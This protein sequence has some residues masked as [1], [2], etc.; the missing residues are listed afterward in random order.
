V[1]LERGAYAADA[2]PGMLDGPLEGSLY[3]LIRARYDQMP[4]RAVERLEPG[5]A[6]PHEAEVLEIEPASAV[7]LVERTAYAADGSAVE[8]SRDVFRGDRTTVVWESE[9]R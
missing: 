9:I 2:F 8:R 7:M 1:A 5:L 6:G 4:V 3:D